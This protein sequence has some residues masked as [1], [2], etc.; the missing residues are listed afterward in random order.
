MTLIILSRNSKFFH[1]LTQQSTCNKTLSY[2][3]P[4]A[5][6]CCEI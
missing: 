2:F 4:R 6:L 5:T 3:S 1:S